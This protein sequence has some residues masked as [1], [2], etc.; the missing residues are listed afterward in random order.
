MI[1]ITSLIDT[2]PACANGPVQS[3]VISIT[4]TELN[5]RP[6]WWTGEKMRILLSSDCFLITDQWTYQP[7][8]PIHILLIRARSSAKDTF[9]CQQR[10]DGPQLGVPLPNMLCSLGIDI[11]LSQIP[12]AQGSD[13]TGGRM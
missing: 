1:C 5:A 12:R 6:R 9:R 11:P 10:S 4:P 8:V 13:Q 2:G 7:L 3:K